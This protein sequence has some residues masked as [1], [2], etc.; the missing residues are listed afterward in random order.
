MNK[1]FF[2]NKS[3]IFISTDLGS[4]S[5]YSNELIFYF[6]YFIKKVFEAL[7]TVVEKVF[8]RVALMQESVGPKLS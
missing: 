3:E 4:S 6:F 1:L 2:V 8:L 7:K 5:S